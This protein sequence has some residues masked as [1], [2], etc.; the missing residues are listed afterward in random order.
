M[1]LRSIAIL[2]AIAVASTVA[3]AQAGVYATFDAQMFN[4]SGIFATAPAGGNSDSPWLYGPT[5]GAFYTIHKIPKL[6]ELHTGPI[7]LGLDGRGDFLHGSLYDRS[8]AIVSLRVTPKHPFKGGLIP[9]VQGGA[10]LGHTKLPHASH[11]SNNWNY[12]FSVGADRK[13]KGHLDW[14]VVEVSGGFLG[15]YVAGANLNQSNY[16]ITLATGL[17][18]HPY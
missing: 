17:V 5:I 8:D 7:S 16:N 11:F 3:H 4:R 10:G 9:Y 12:Q 18:F 14:R 13:L 15:N 1:K 2:S 6:G